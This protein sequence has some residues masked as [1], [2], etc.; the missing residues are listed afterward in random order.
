MEQK[1]INEIYEKFI[2]F[3]K[4][5]QK[6][7]INNGELKII[8]SY[9]ERFDKFF[10]DRHINYQE[11]RNIF[12]ECEYLYI[13]FSLFNFDIHLEEKLN[14][15]DLSSGQTFLLAYIGF[16]TRY[17]RYCKI[18]DKKSLNIIIDECETSLH[19][20]WQKQIL[21]VFLDVVEKELSENLKINFLFISHSPFILSD[22]PKQNVIFLEKDEKTGKCVN[23]TEKIKNLNTFGA[24]IHTLLSHGFFMKDGLIGEFAKSKIDDLINYLNNKESQIKNDENAQNIINII[25]EPIIKRE[26]QRM[27]DS[28]RL[29]K[30]DKIDGIEKQI[31][32]LQKELKKIKND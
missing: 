27:L 2:N 14:Y 12:I 20:N 18:N 32:E 6:E 11:I 10:Q 22:L 9:L 21:K 3:E 17:I 30:I 15:K 29:S 7:F 31:E 26:L 8:E 25:G 5:E 16:I 24:N 28:K 23:S 13:L 1:E 19:P 4:K